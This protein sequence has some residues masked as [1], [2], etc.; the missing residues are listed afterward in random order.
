VNAKQR[1]QANPRWVAC[2]RLREHAIRQQSMATRARPCH[3]RF[4]D[5]SCSSA[6][7]VKQ[8]GATG[9]SPVFPVGQH[10]QDARG[11]RHAVTLIEVL[12]VLVIL[13]LIAATVWPSLERSLADQ[14][15]RAAADMVRAE[16]GHARTKAMSSGIAYQFCYTPDER[17]YWIEPCEDLQAP[18]GQS[19]S[20]QGNSRPAAQPEPDKQQ[21]P[22][23]ITFLRG[24][25]SEQS[26]ETM[27]ADQTPPQDVVP[28]E[29]ENGESNAPIVFA[30]DGTCSSGEL[31]LGNEY[32]R[33][34]TVTIHRLTAIA[35][36]GEIFNVEEGLP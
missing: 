5:T 20:T 22:E 12:L 25:A 17:T 7:A 32:E 11:T 1:R 8:S 18:G 29:L 34:I 6:S 4:P 14:R 36:V 21:L 13:V 26:P 10:G 33:G 23:E 19:S 27:S 28:P 35:A 3:P 15:L 2:S 16:W 30:P 31:V 9:V 24:R